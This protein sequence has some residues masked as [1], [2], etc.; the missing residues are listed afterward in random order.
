MIAQPV[1]HM[2]GCLLEHAWD[3]VQPCQVVLIILYIAE[4]RIEDERRVA[5]M[6]AANLGRRHFPS[7]ELGGFNLGAQASHHQHLVEPLPLREAGYVDRFEPVQRLT[8]MHE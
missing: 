7:L 5:E 1:T 6:N 3:L 4:G 2:S 8:R